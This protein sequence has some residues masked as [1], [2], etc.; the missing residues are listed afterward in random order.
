MSKAY[1]VVGVIA[2]WSETV[3]GPRAGTVKNIVGAFFGAAQI[4]KEFKDGDADLIEVRV[5]FASDVRI[6]ESYEGVSGGALWEL[7]SELLD[8]PKIAS[9]KKQLHGIAFRQSKDSYNHLIVCNGSLGI[10]RLI[11]S[12]LEKWPAGRAAT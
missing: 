5:D 1:A 8:G 6:P 9:I 10:E 12:A 2:E 11:N 4:V 7:H 3:A